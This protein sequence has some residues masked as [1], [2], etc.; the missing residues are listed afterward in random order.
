MKNTHESLLK[1]YTPYQAQKNEAYMN[2][3]Q[4]EHFKAILVAWKKEL[5]EESQ[6]IKHV[7]LLRNMRSERRSE[8]DWRNEGQFRELK[9]LSYQQ[10]CELQA[11]DF[12]TVG[13]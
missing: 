4:E 12:K 3:A 2:S 6:L 8:E 5:M 13:Q 1:H 11:S 10:H 7:N 9:P